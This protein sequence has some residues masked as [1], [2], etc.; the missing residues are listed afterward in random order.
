VSHDMPHMCD[1]PKTVGQPKTVSIHLL[2]KPTSPPQHAFVGKRAWQTHATSPHTVLPTPVPLSLMQAVAQ[3]P[4]KHSSSTS[5][6]AATRTQRNTASAQQNIA[7]QAFRTGHC[8]LCCNACS[9][10]PIA[11]LQLPV[12]S[13]VVRVGF[14]AGRT[15]VAK[16]PP[17]SARHGTQSATHAASHVGGA[18]P[19]PH[20]SA[21]KAC[22]STPFPPR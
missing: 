5:Q 14:M 18:C 9:V 11:A 3:N 12:P 15:G 20:I 1:K 8:H 13:P 22:S 19:L 10:P 16:P 4:Q 2:L 6:A 17:T 7:D 21:A